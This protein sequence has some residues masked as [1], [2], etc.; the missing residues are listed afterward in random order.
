MAADGM[1]AS[2]TERAVS[3]ATPVAS[4]TTSSCT[5]PIDM[6]SWS[7]TVCPTSRVIASRVASAKPVAVTRRSKLEGARLGTTKVPSG[8]DVAE[9]RSPVLRSV[10]VTL[11]AGTGA[12][13]GSVT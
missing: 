2:T 10:R 11:A 7:E 13:C 4:T 12:P 5:A 1:T 8:A 9:R 3:T 6:T